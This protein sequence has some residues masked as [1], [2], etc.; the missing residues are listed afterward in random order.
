MALGSG[1]IKMKGLKIAN[2]QESHF[3]LRPHPS[4]ILLEHNS[5]APDIIEIAGNYELYYKILFHEVR[6][7]FIHIFMIF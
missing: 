5:N 7:F 1:Q 2:F 6:I 3:F 4:G